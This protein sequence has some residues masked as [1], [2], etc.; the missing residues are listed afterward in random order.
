MRPGSDTTVRVMKRLAIVC[1]VALATFVAQ[2]TVNAAS[3]SPGPSLSPRLLV[4]H[5]IHE[6]IKAGCLKALT[7]DHR[8]K[9]LAIVAD[10]DSG[11]LTYQDADA[12]V[13]KVLTDDE[14]SAIQEQQTAMTKMWRAQVTMLSDSTVETPVR[15]RSRAQLVNFLVR[16]LGNP[17]RVSSQMDTVM[18][19]P[20]AT[21]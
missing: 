17:G 19:L 16:M 9:V 21:P 10:F 11:K 8:T 7:P 4:A 15:P 5:Q 13:D 18:P 2:G 12:A 3:P 14:I 6:T 1:L 20:S